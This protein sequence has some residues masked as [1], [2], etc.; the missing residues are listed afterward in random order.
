MKKTLF[1]IAM[2]AAITA[3][4][5]SGTQNNA[6]QPA[7]NNALQ[8]A[9]K[10]EDLLNKDW[11]LKELN[12]SSIVLDTTFPNYPHMKFENLTNVG[13]NLGCNGFG[14]N[15]KVGGAD[16][17]SFSQ[18]VSTQ[19]ACPNLDIENRF[20][21]ALENT[22]TFKI[23]GNTLLLNNDRKEVIAKLENTAN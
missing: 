17:I 22:K 21:T 3:C 2:A 15:V 5:D 14:G 10:P 6:D 4:N 19:M 12:G 20:R 23:D 7:E 9:S 1:I 8:T 16:S 13:G 18:V 11:R